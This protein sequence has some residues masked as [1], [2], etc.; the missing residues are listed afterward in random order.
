M[1]S[2]I[3]CPIDLGWTTGSNVVIIFLAMCV[4][5]KDIGKDETLGKIWITWIGSY[6]FSQVMSLNFRINIKLNLRRHFNSVL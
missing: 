1:Y 5:G 6:S 4:Q 2:F 3:C